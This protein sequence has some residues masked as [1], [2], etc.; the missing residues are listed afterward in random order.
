MGFAADFWF[1]GKVAGGLLALYAVLLLL[2]IAAQGARVLFHHL[3]LQ[4]K[5][6]AAIAGEA[7]ALAAVWPI[8][9]AVDLFEK[10]VAAG[11]EWR[12]QRKIWRNEFRTLMPWA[13]FRL[14]MTG[15]GKAERDEYTD[16]L[17]LYGLTEP[18][19][20]PE[21]DA[22]FKRIMQSVHPDKGGTDYLAQLVTAARTRILKQKGWK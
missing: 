9:H 1:F 16:A 18:F 13:E 8:E 15:R 12:A 19:T 21:L 2:S 22:R 3:S 5:K 7:I 10:W 4:T 20:R 11:S 14:K 17:S 6:L